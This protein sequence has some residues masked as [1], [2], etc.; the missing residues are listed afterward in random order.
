MKIKRIEYWTVEMPLVEPY[1]IAYETVDKAT[2]IFLRLETDGPHCGFA[3]TAPD[4]EVTG[5]TPRSVLSGLEKYVVPL[6]VGEDP[7]RIYMH[8]EKLKELA[9][10]KPALIAL[11]DIALHDLLA[12]VAGLPLYRILGGYRQCIPTSVTIGILPWQETL[13]R[14]EK[15]FSAG[16]SIL[17]IKG[18]VELEED[19]ERIRKLRERFGNEFELRFDANQ[20]YSKEEALRFFRETESCQGAIFEQPTPRAQQDLLG[21]ITHSV[22]LRIM[23]DESISDLLDAFHLARNDWVDMLNIK[24][25]KVGGIAEGLRIL[26]VAKAAKLEAMVGCLDESGLGIA[27]G[28]HFALSRPHITCAD[29]DGHLDLLDDPAAEAVLIRKG[30]MYPQDQPGLGFVLEKRRSFPV[31]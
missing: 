28:L 25:I 22:P 24:L 11:V 9:G 10:R 14:A 19:I 20:G 15:W 31:A 21:E 12:R 23:A 4:L 7:L 16:F 5:E 29:L 18:G 3:C 6:L 8:L 27:A 1:R 17:K 13:A 26:S 2:N 30:I